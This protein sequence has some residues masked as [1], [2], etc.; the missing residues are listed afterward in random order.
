VLEQNIHFDTTL[1]SVDT[2][3]AQATPRLVEASK[4]AVQD[5]MQRGG[6]FASTVRGY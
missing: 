1:E 6:G 2:R 5:A 3:I 4:S